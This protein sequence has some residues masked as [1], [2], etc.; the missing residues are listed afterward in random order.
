[1][2][3]IRPYTIHPGWRLLLIDAGIDPANVLRR[4]ELPDD[5]FAHDRSVLSGDEHFRLWRGIEAEADDPLLPLRLGA[6]ISV[7]AFDPPIFA[8]FCSPDLNTALQRIARYKPLVGPMVLHVDVGPSRTSMELEWLDVTTPP[9]ASLV[10]TEL[11]FFVTVVR[12][13]TRERICPLEIRSPHL[14]DPAKPYTEHFGVPVKKGK[15]LRHVF[16][17]RDA[18]RPFLTANEKMWEHFEPDLRRRLYDLDQ[19]A[20]TADR[21]QAVL[22]ELLPGEGTSMPRVARRLG[23]SSRTLQR[24]LKKEGQTYQGVLNRTREDLARHY[25]RMTDL[26]GAKISYLLGYEDPNCFFRAYRGWTGTT[27]EQTR[28][29]LR[30]NH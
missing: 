5:L 24:R 23:T 19:T 1:M 18:A 22:L 10:L 3:R 6:A 25:L 30:N 29:T 17:A 2:A 12:I 26:P 20:T 14:P 9:P 21:V 15:L 28:S 13:A 4:A 27:P 8:F 16:S 11:T 7:E